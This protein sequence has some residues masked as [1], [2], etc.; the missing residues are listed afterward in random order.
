VLRW[1]TSRRLSLLATAAALA[2]AATTVGV[3][4][5]VPGVPTTRASAQS[6]QDCWEERRVIVG[7]DENGDPLF[8]VVL[9]NV[10]ESEGDGG[11]GG[12]PNTCEHEDHGEFPCYDPGRGWWSNS[13]GCYV[14]SLSPQPPAGD[15]RWEGNDPDEGAVYVLYCPLAPSGSGIF[16]ESYEFLDEAPGV[17]SVSQLAQQAMDSL[18]LVGADIGIAPSP[19]GVGLVGLHVWMWTENTD[20]TWGPVSVSVSV[21]GITVTAQGEAD[22]IEWN[23][24]DGST[25]VC[26]GPG[27]PYEARFGNQSSPSGCD[28][29]YTEPSRNQPDGRYPITAT[30]SWHVEWWVEPRG[31]AAED[32]Q[33]FSRVSSTSVRINELQVVTS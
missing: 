27:T 14:S 28:H 32:E 33:F 23:M 30:T 29:V 25:V 10:C 22:Q 2:G 8:E 31:S 13:L 11:S 3:V 7:E 18:P 4:G 6:G 17:P 5:A 16:R 19:D 1:R 12:G 15:P 26:D 20:A 21:P 9:V 24:G